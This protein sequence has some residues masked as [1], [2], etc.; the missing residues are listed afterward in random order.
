MRELKKAVIGLAEVFG[1]ELSETRLA[2]YAEALADLPEVEVRRA[3]VLMLRDPTL[4]RFP[5]PAE[6]RER[7]TPTGNPDHDAIEAANRI[8]EALSKFGGCNADLEAPKARAFIGE[9]GWKV[10]EREGGWSRLV[11][12]V[13]TP[14][15]PTIK[16]QWREL[17]KAIQG[18]ARMGTLDTAPGIP[19]PAQ[20]MVQGLAD[21]LSLG[22][23]KK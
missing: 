15:L 9:L 4:K 13:T 10:V 5:T 2:L 12:D 3:I 8:V 23:G 22:K 14:Q 18:R 21:K 6:I 19:G 1:L 17:A 16:A 7:I 11:E 20:E